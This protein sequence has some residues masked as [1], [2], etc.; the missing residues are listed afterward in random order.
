[1]KTVFT[2][3]ARQSEKRPWL[4]VLVVVLVTAFLAAGL[5]RIKTELN[6]EAMMPKNY[7][8]IQ[9]FEEFTDAFGGF[10]SETLLIT[11]E[12]VTDPEITRA[13]LA[14]SPEMLEE[15]GFPPG[16][17]IKVD[18][19]LDFLKYTLPEMLKQAGLD[20]PMSMDAVD[21]AV[22]AQFLDF[23]LDP[24][25]GSPFLDAFAKLSGM[26]LN[27]EAKAQVVAAFENNSAQIKDSVIK[28]GEDGTYTATLVK[29]Y[30]NTDVNSNELTE[31][32]KK[33]KDFAAQYFGSIEGVETYLS[34]EA[35][36]QKD[37]MDFI[38]Q[39]TSKLLIIALL[40]ILLILYLT[41]RRVSDIFLP[42]LII[43]V[44]IFWVIGL[45][46]WVGITY[47]V[48]S[49]AIMPLLMGINIAYVIHILSR[50]YEEREDGL[51]VDLSA[52]TSVKTVGVA[53]FLAAITT[54]FGFCSFMITDIPPM[55]D[56]GL[57]CVLGITFSF[58][59]SLTLLPAIVVIRD[60]RK[61]DEKLDAHL[62]KMRTGRRDA[63][64]GVFIDRA[65][66][67]M[68]LV[69]ERHHWAVALV[70]AILVVAAVFSL[71][72]AK[73][74]ADVRKMFPKNMPSMQA[75][76]KIEEIFGPQSFD[77]IL[78][79]G[80]IYDP[81]NLEALLALEDAIVSDERN[82]PEKIGY[83]NREDI[84]SIADVLRNEDG[85]LPDSVD[86][87]RE[88]LEMMKNVPQLK[89]FIP[90]EREGLPPMTV[91]MLSTAIP[92]V[93]DE[94]AIKTDIMRDN[95]AAVMEETGL[96]LRPT[97]LT[98]LV[99]D[100][101]G[102]IMTTQM[103]TSGMA[104]LLCALVLIIVFRSFKYGLATLSVV[105]CGIACELVFL[106]V[107]GWPLDLM[108]VMVSSLIIGAGIDFGIHITHRFREEWQQGDLPLEEVLRNTVLH[109]GRA[110]IAAALTTAG[111]FAILGFSSMSMMQRFGWTTTVGL[112]GALLGAE[113]VLPS[114]L[115]I[116][117]NREKVRRENTAAS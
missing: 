116:L 94:L 76:Q 74:G 107:M 27:E 57:L 99:A 90:L 80:D 12:D 64:Y 3:L 88:K 109:V 53:V 79:E 51:S 15:N 36:M 54:V 87:V 44:G 40:F 66:V 60:R 10:A 22:M 45:M 30:L 114:I 111:V 5:P 43:A 63:R 86:A 6:Q 58:L 110:L 16:Q 61:A 32:G 67:R 71:F 72:T 106:L 48:M 105:V 14:L 39:E 55:R 34:G 89:A 2:F 68:A 19:Y 91:V 37:A 23:Y 31:L 9:A 102:R 65:L 93:E 101:L 35:S 59:L 56:F 62:E 100:L 52:T 42:L 96:K 115:A 92:E 49:V 81:A 98:V 33:F 70:T 77:I 13:L 85:T 1:M 26:S 83:F 8:S 84:T 20:M 4:V 18:T 117:A 50:Y 29:F 113:L 75:S 46:G 41:F 24:D 82:H 11:A 108:T 69:S 112:L 7:E 21:D 38:N 95:C 17:V 103:Q 78:V 73:T 28:G 97:G 25:P 104:L 47:T